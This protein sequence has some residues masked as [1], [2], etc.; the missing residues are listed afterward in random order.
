MHRAANGSSRFRVFDNGFL[1]IAGLAAV[2]VGCTTVADR[3][4]GVSPSRAM[5]T[6]CT[7]QCKDLY[8]I[9]VAQESKLREENIGACRALPQPERG[10]CL[11]EEGARHAEEMARLQQLHADCLSSCL[12]GT[13]PP[14]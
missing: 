5:P 12:K 4:T 9:L 2:L 7:H 3:L 6:T 14:G 1:M 8:S 13:I 10:A 11:E